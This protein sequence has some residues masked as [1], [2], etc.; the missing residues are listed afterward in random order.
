MLGFRYVKSA[1]WLLVASLLGC[2]P[3]IAAKKIRRS[4]LVTV[5]KE[6]FQGEWTS[7]GSAHGVGCAPVCAF[8]QR[9]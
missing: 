8:L 9:P 7:S 4:P 3:A 6:R 1:A 2:P 5:G